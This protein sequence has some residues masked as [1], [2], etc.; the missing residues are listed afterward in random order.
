[1]QERYAEEQGKKIWKVRNNK[2]RNKRKSRT[3]TR[4]EKTMTMKTINRRIDRK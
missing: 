2:E 3:N 1:M 4:T